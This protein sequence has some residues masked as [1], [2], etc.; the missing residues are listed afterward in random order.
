MSGKSRAGSALRFAEVLL[1]RVV[2]FLEGVSRKL[3]YFSMV[4]PDKEG[5]KG[6]AYLKTM[7]GKN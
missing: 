3:T 1:V 5:E 4:G 2:S 6:A 7:F